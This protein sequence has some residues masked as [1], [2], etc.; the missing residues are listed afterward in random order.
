MFILFF[1]IYILTR[2]KENDFKIIFF[3][4]L[5]LLFISLTVILLMIK[6]NQGEK[7]S[8][9]S[10]TIR[11]YD[12]F[13]A[14]KLF[15]QKPIFGYGFEAQDV[16]MELQGFD[17]GCSNGIASCLYITGLW[18][19]I[20]NFYPFILKKDKTLILYLYLIFYFISNMTEPFILQP[21]MTFILV[22]VYVTKLLSGVYINE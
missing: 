8:Y 5:F 13:I 1:V 6:N 9:N 14:L 19:I 4:L 21:F 17:R 10:L 18:G 3:Q 16:F 7:G 20:F 12:M 11:L 15:I 22:F 2:I